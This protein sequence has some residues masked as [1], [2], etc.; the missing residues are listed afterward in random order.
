MIQVNRPSWFGRESAGAL[1]RCVAH[2][3]RPAAG[4]PRGRCQTLTITRTDSGMGLAV[5][6]MRRSPM[7]WNFRFTISSPMRSPRTSSRSSEGILERRVSLSSFFRRPFRVRRNHAAV[8]KPRNVMRPPNVTLRPKSRIFVERRGT[9][10]DVW[11]FAAGCNDVT[12]A[13]RTK[14]SSLARRRFIGRQLVLT[15][16]PP[17]ILPRDAPGCGKCRGVRFSTGYAMTVPERV[18]TRNFVR[19]GSAMTAALHLGFPILRRLSDEP[20]GAEWTAR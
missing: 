2:G 17:K 11:R 15:A 7:R 16:K 4:V 14:E 18:E 9:Q 8:D 1:P 12:A 3:C 19:Y 5:E 13:D 6:A 10:K 20:N